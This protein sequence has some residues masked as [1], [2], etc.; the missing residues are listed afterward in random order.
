MVKFY[1]LTFQKTDQNTSYPAG[2][3]NC[4][5]TN[6]SQHLPK[7]KLVNNF[8]TQYSNTE[9]KSFNLLV[10]SNVIEGWMYSASIGQLFG[11]LFWITI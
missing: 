7:Y 6:Y 2:K 8:P 10:Q 4:P 9:F 1:L 3:M 5:L 11:S